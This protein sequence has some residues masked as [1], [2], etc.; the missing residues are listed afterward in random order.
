MSPVNTADVHSEWL[1]SACIWGVIY[2]LLADSGEGNGGGR[3]AKDSALS[4]F[5]FLTIAPGRNLLSLNPS[6]ELLEGN[7]YAPG[8]PLNQ[9]MRALPWP[10]YKLQIA[11]E[12]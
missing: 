12:M 9:E 1:P 4:S 8:F 11:L 5:L 7:V 10:L 6:M 2:W 3:R